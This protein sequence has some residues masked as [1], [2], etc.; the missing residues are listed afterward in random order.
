MPSFDNSGDNV[1]DSLANYA[2][3]GASLYN[4][5]TG[6]GVPNA[7]ATTTTAPAKKNW[8]LIGGIA[9]AVVVVLLVVTRK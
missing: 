9:A 1:L 6:R 4:S 8:L 7:Q 3:T 5:I 2:S